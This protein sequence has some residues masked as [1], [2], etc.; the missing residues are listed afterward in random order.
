MFNMHAIVA[1]QPKEFPREGDQ[2][3]MTVLINAG[4]AN[5]ALGRMNIVRMSLQLLFMLDIL[6]ASGNKIS[7][8]ILSYRSLGKAWSNMR[9]PNEHPTDSD[10]QLW[11]STMLWIC[12]S[13][14]SKSRIGQFIGRLHRIWRWYW[15]N[16]ESTLHC[17]N[18]NSKTENIYVSGQK[19]INSST[20]TAN[21]AMSMR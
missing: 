18:T 15:S 1:D 20:P 6:M 4:Y 5:K 16:T 2:F 10:M 19:Q 3:I 8:E 11:R 7:I 12:P 21:P 13:R 9:W 17:V 14:T